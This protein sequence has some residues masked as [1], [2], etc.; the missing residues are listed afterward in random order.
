VEVA[1]GELGIELD[2]LAQLLDGEVRTAELE[3]DE[4]QQVAI[5][6]HVRIDTDRFL[7]RAQRRR[8][9]PLAHVPKRALV[10]GLSAI[11]VGIGHLRGSAGGS[12][13][14]LSAS[15]TPRRVDTFSPPM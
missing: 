6:G 11:P 8:R 4:P 14:T 1:V 13:S 12:N 2:R 3:I 9:L 10:G 5:D 7:E 15:A